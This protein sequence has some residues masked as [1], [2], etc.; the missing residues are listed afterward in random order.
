MDLEHAFRRVPAWARALG[1]A[2]RGMGWRRRI[3]EDVFR[4]MLAGE[5]ATPEARAPHARLRE[6]GEAADKP[7]PESPQAVA[8]PAATPAGAA[9]IA[10]KPAEK[11][12]G[13]AKPEGERPSENAARK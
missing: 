1:Q 13:S 7:A 5:H 12:P 3:A 9:E 10:P 2:F 4:G 8:R 11:A 6:P